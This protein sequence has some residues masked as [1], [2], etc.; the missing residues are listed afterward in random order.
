MRSTILYLSVLCFLV[1]SVILAG[2][3][4]TTTVQGALPPAPIVP[5]STPTPTPSP[6]PATFTAS[7]FIYGVISFEAEGG[8]FG[9]AIDSANGT[10]TS[11][12]GSPAANPLGQNIV[13]QMAA[14]P[15]G[16]FL[17]ALNI[18]ASSFG[19][20]FGQIGIA[21][22]RINQANGALT[23]VPNSIVFPQ[24]RFG[25][26]AIDGTGR[27]LYQPNGAG[28]DVYRINQTTG[29][30]NLAPGTLP[31]PAVGDFSAASPDGRFLF[32]AGNGQVEVYG[33]DQATGQLTTAISPVTTG[34]SA[35]P[36]AVSAD[37]R[38][39]YVA[40]P[41]QG[42]VAVYL[43]GS[44]GR[45]VLQ[46]G[47]PFTTDLLAAGMSLSPDGKFLYMT[48]QN[49]VESHVK[50]YAVNPLAGSFTPIAAAT[51]ANANSINVDGSGRFAYVAQVQLATYRID[52]NT[53]ALTLASQ[54]SQPVTDLPTNIVLT[55]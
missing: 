44:D 39:L 15:R 23:A 22:Y 24:Q 29:D 30:L 18:G 32:D 41:P 2:C 3:G 33:I 42:T 38:F 17:Y 36:M 1:L 8:V 21:G 55:P 11:A 16:R 7:R 43:I 52:A 9:G 4:A 40:N 6:T 46:S 14:D 20:Q 12:T 37:S 50:G 10:V 49:G 53:G 48:F 47:S 28:I 27:F 13:I 45:L 35:G 34:G 26:M 54:A 19:I 25:L 51:V 31:A 5:P